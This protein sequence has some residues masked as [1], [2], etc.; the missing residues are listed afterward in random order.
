MQKTSPRS[1]AKREAVLDA[2]QDCFLEL[3]YAGTSMDAVAARAGVS[4]A[5][6]YAHFQGKD[7]LFGAIMRRRCEQV[8]PDEMPPPAPDEDAR[9]VLRAVAQRLLEL[10]MSPEAAAVY[11]IVVAES[12]R[13]PDLARAF[14]EAGPE[15]SR[16]LLGATLTF[17]AER[18]DL[19][20][21]DPWIA[22]DQFIGML[23]AEALHRDLFGLP[24]RP[25]CTVDTTVNAAV[26]TILR[27]YAP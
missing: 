24:P 10:M 14:Y 16:G 2:A 11:R 17:L 4:K 20:V 13:A 18:G 5:T 6:I 9:T 8:I 26:E 19:V 22:A 3:G 21:P 1:S 12:L 15:R 7:E 25:G 27:A 23:R